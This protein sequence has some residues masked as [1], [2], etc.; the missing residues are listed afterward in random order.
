L[1]D[2]KLELENYEPFDINDYNQF[3]VEASDET[4]NSARILSDNIGRE[5]RLL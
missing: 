1:I 5:T 3:M 4:L 2:D